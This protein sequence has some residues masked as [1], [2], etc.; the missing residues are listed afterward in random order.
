MAINPQDLDFYEKLEDAFR[1]RLQP[2]AAAG[3]TVEIA[4]ENS[5]DF[6]VSFRHGR[7]RIIYRESDYQPIADVGAVVQGE[8][9]TIEVSVESRHRRGNGGVFAMMQGCRALLLGW[10]PPG[11]NRKIWMGRQSFSSIDPR[12]AWEYMQEFKTAAV[13][14][15]MEEEETGPLL[16]G[17]ST[18]T[19]IITDAG[20]E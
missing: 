17:I 14:M 13:A 18:D 4:P 1:D 5:E 16:E 6:S 8:H 11:C 7:I 20:Q 19:T 3:F 2:L 10:R 12:G 9:L 15:E